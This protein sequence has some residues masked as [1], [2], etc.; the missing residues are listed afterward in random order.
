MKSDFKFSNKS[1]GF[2]NPNTKEAIACLNED[3]QRG[4][5]RNNGT[6]SVNK[7]PTEKDVITDIIYTLNH[8][9]IHALHHK[10]DK[11]SF[12]TDRKSTEYIVYYMIGNG[13]NNIFHWH[14]G[15]QKNANWEKIIS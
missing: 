5:H 14:Y 10:L 15:I 6:F 4:G 9:Y 13:G 8:E 11:H 3:F 1:F 7:N 2:Y 12:I